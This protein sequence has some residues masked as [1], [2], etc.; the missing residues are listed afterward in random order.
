MTVVTQKDVA[1]HASVSRKTVSNVI[2]GRMG[3]VSTMTAERVRV[4]VAALGYRPNVAARSLRQARVGVLALAIPDL[5][6]PYFAELSEAVL[7]A[8][9]SRNTTVLIDFTRGAREEELLV[10]GGLRPH[11][12]DGVILNALELDIV[13]IEPASVGMPLLLIGERLA[14]APYDHVM[15]DNVAAAHLATRHLV[16]IGRRRVAVVGMSGSPRDTMA[17]LR[18]RG[19]EQALAAAGIPVD[20]G[21]VVA[22]PPVSFSR[23]NGID[24]MQRLL[25]T[26]HMFDAVLCM[27]DLIALGAME[28]LRAVGY[29]IPEDVAVVGFD[30]IQEGRHSTPPLT[31]IAPD[32]VEI[33]RLAVSLL[34]AR[35]DGTRTGPPELV[36]PTFRL[37][38]RQSTGGRAQELAEELP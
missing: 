31:T 15:I 17:T 12:I 34:L 9:S 23:A 8:A 1:E 28:V 19:Y 32:K 29:R 37:L 13:D 6:N 14:G 11:L 38:V 27:N 25:A 26:G 2:N 30:D 22:V 36:R 35:I 21:L 20:P 4:S 3:R 5:G 16:R 24:G 33:G 18:L 7:D 10:A